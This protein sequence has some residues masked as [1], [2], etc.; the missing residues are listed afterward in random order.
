MTLELRWVA[1]EGTTATKPR[2][3]WRT[4]QSNFTWGEWADIPTVV[5]PR[6]P[7]E[8]PACCGGGPQWGHGSQF[9]IALHELPPACCGG[10]PQWGHAWTCKNCPD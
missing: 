9:G 2:L 4:K 10:G 5:V 7:G 8:P 6:V 3:Q 1:Q